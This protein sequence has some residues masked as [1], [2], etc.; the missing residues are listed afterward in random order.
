MM[1]RMIAWRRFITSNEILRTECRVT[2]TAFKEKGF[3]KISPGGTV[4]N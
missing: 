3:P 2:D 4:R 1:P